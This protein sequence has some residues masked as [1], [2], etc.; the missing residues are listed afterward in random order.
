MLANIFEL[1]LFS[2]DSGLVDDKHWENWASVWKNVILPDEGFAEL[3]LD[4][5]IYTFNPDAHTLATAWVKEQREQHA[6]K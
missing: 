5:T 1:A 2:R 6:A 4:K 3:M